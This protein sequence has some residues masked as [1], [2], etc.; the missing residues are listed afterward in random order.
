M[1]LDGQPVLGLRDKMITSQYP[2]E[3]PEKEFDLPSV[4]VQES[5]NFGRQVSDGVWQRGV[6]HLP[7]KPRAFWGA[8]GA[9]C[10]PRP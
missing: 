5:N 10:R 1:D 7:T 8:P 6:P 3:P 4:F 2:L 9:M